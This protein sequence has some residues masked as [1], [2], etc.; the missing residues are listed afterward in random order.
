MNEGQWTLLIIVFLISVVALVVALLQ[1]ARIRRLERDVL[2]LQDATLSSER[3]SVS[4]I[5]AGSDVSEQVSRVAPRPNPM[6]PNRDQAARKSAS[7]PLSAPPTAELAGLGDASSRRAGPVAPPDEGRAKAARTDSTVLR[8]QEPA[9]AATF[10]KWIA[11]NWVYSVSALSLALAGIFLIQYSIENALISP[12][13]RLLLALAFGG[14][15]IAAGQYVRRRNAHGHSDGETTP[16][17]YLPSVFSGAGL[18]VLYSTAIAAQ[19]LYGFIGAGTAFF[20]LVAVS[21]LGMV[22]GWITGSLLAGIGL[23]G[24]CLAPFVIQ[25]N[26]ES[27]TPF[28][29][30]FTIV[31][32][33]GLAIDTMRRWAWVSVLALVLPAAAGCAVFLM[34]AMRPDDAF[35]F[36][37]MLVALTLGAFAIPVRSLWPNHEGPSFDLKMPPD[38]ATFDG[39]IFPAWLVAG[40]M[41]VS[42]IVLILLGVGRE[43]DFQTSLVLLLVL[44]AAVAGWAHRAPALTS[45]SALPAL[46]FVLLVGI[47]AAARLST[48]T[49]G[50]AT[51][52]AN[53]GAFGGPVTEVLGMAAL[54]SLLAFWRGLRGDAAVYWARVATLFAPVT[55]V[56]FELT[57]MQGRGGYSFALQILM[58][59]ALMVF[60]AERYGRTKG[61]DRRPL[62]YAVL[63]ALSLIALALFALFEQAALTVALG[64]LVAAAAWLDRRFQLREMTVF[65]GLGVVVLSYRQILDPGLF[66]ALDSAFWLVSLAFI[67]P[68]IALVS[69][70]WCLRP[71]V[72][73]TAKIFL[74]S[75]VIAMAG[76]F[77][78]LV[79]YRFLAWAIDDDAF[80][81]HYAMG[82]AA[83]IWMMLALVQLYRLQL[84]GRL[85]VV[86]LSLI[87]VYGAISGGFLLLG[88]TLFSPLDGRTNPI[89]GPIVLD[90]VLVAY[91]LPAIMLIFASSFT[92][93]KLRFVPMGLGIF[94]AAL[95]VG[96]EIRRIWWG[97][98]VDLIQ[99]FAQGELYAYTVALL[100]AG[101]ALLYQ[102]IVRRSDLMR[103]IALGVI[104]LAVLKVFLI[105]MSGLMGLLRVFS[106]LALGLA[107]AALA[108]FDRWAMERATPSGQGNPS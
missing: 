87:G 4:T 27:A 20:A 45:L 13:V 48:L 60:F 29:I 37:V 67:L 94:L 75:G 92:Q 78:V 62:A 10:V 50:L 55:A 21:A 58:I 26:A 101:A 82:L 90:T 18:V 98:N 79:L 102:A 6:L 88:L 59:A 56:M 16:S 70:F 106:F 53:L 1:A 36:K 64:V 91:V 68:M 66:W 54:G 76:V 51:D 11:E 63:S 44:F 3:P 35:G 97:K 65:I 24:A 30:Y 81:T 89:F 105:D 2:A 8:A 22:L 104:G 12:Q 86:R 42:S 38:I 93:R 39:P 49:G 61:A 72:R 9:Q 7:V 77:A 80:G 41:L 25:G 28:Y 23:V 73:V 15:L 95:Y 31:G 32:L 40:S 96:I 46:G 108:W 71:L 34:T 17:A 107:L 5:S 83:C 14:A 84:G 103:R 19:V 85:R 52:T 100:L 57:W 43:L 99:G 47:D 74:E 33:M 69:A